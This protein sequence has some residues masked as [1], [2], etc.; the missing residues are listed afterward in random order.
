MKRLCGTCAP[1]QQT[2]WYRRRPKQTI[3]FGQIWRQVFEKF[4]Y[5]CK[6]CVILLKNLCKS[7]IIGL[8][9]ADILRKIRRLRK[10]GRKEPLFPSPVCFHVPL[11]D[12]QF[13]R[14]RSS[15]Y[16]S[17]PASACPAISVSV[18][19]S[20][21]PAISLSAP[22][23]ARLFRCLPA[24]PPS[25]SAALLPASSLPLLRRG[26]A[27]SGCSGQTVSVPVQ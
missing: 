2:Q 24:F 14:F 5:V 23:S 16:W 20:A 25:L 10:N 6:S 3:I 26:P 13:W 15:I 11:S 21:R 8:L 17:V 4:S 7:G 18:P 27:S 1:G 22:A 9:R 12:R 19:A